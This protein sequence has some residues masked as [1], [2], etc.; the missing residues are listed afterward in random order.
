MV[1]FVIDFIANIVHEFLFFKVIN[2][3]FMLVQ[4]VHE[5]SFFKVIKVKFML[6]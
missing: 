3:K 4:C 5:F 1:L 2:V 6:V